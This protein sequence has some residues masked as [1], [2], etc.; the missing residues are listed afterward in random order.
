VALILA[1]YGRAKCDLF[2]RESFLEDLRPGVNLPETRLHSM[3]FKNP[4]LFFSVKFPGG[5][6]DNVIANGKKHPP[7]LLVAGTAVKSFLDSLK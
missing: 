2:F 6:Y 1:I 3:K 5:F 7:V 4:Y